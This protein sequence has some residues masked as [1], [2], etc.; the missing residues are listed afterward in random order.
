[1]IQN[2]TSSASIHYNKTL[3]TLFII[4]SLIA[5]FGTL[6]YFSVGDCY[7]NCENYELNYI[8]CLNEGNLYCCSAASSYYFN[9]QCTLNNGC[10]YENNNCG[11]LLISSA[12]V[13]G[14]ILVSIVAIII[15]SLR[16]KKPQIEQKKSLNL[17]V[18]LLN[19][20]IKGK[21]NR[22]EDKT[23]SSS[24]VSMR[25]ILDLEN[26]DEKK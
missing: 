10:I 26:K 21:Y 11:K 5:S 25:D 18:P 7:Q 20:D 2:S 16:T 4:L 15:L 9:Q 22:E 19:E 3:F 24:I 1:M 17:K 14:L 13:G 6:I 8:P 12:V 23:A